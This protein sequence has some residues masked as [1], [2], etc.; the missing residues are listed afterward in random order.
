LPKPII[1]DKHAWHAESNNGARVMEA[2]WREAGDRGFDTVTFVAKQ[3]GYIIDVVC[4]IDS[5]APAVSKM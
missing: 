4:R 5:L 2:A 3:S 1:D